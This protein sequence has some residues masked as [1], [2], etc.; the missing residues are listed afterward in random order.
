MMWLMNRVGGSAVDAAMAPLRGLP[1]FWSL[2]VLALATAVGMLLVFRATLDV[3]GVERAKRRTHA[4]IFEM[5]LFQDDLRA[6]LRAA[7]EV[8]RHNATYLRAWLLPIAIVSLPL[9]LLIGQLECFYGSA[10]LTPGQSALLVARMRQTS[11]PQPE[12]GAITLEAPPDVRVD[13]TA[14][15]FPGAGEAVWRVSPVARGDFDLR[16]RVG[17]T[18]V[19]KTLQ[20]SDLVVRRSPRRVGTGLVDEFL[21]PSEPPLPADGPVASVDVGYPAAEVDVV[22]WHVHWLVPYLGWLFVFAYVLKRPFGVVF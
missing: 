19:G 21:Y 11:G 1:P 12:A 17:R 8:V 6:V 16:L 2:G 13:T 15:W 3:A 9:T 18:I 5:R 22:G 7:A 14:L 20:V 4:A 10:G